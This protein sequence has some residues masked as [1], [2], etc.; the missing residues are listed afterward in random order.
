MCNVSYSCY[1]FELMIGIKA[2]ITNEP[3]HP[4]KGVFAR[5]PLIYGL[6]TLVKGK[7]FGCS[8]L[9]VPRNSHVPHSYIFHKVQVSIGYL[10]DRFWKWSITQ[11]FPL[12]PKFN[13][14]FFI[15]LR[16]LFSPTQIKC[17][18]N[19]NSSTYILYCN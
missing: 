4:L 18:S 11:V 15:T 1:Q 12:K 14:A 16:W 3:S 2:L 6:C 10:T 8:S 17:T 13:L 5:F 7:D 19:A 9:K